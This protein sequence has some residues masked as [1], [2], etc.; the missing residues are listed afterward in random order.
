MVVHLKLDIRDILV[1]ISVNVYSAIKSIVAQKC[2][3]SPTYFF[4]ESDINARG[5][6]FLQQEKLE[7]A[8]VMFKCNVDMFP[9]SWNVYD[10]YGEALFRLGDFAA[11]I[12]NY[13]KSLE[14]N[15]ES[16]SGKEMLEQART[17]AAGS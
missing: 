9:E 15:P 4:L 7:Q 14:L 13:E 6:R 5:Y 8:A 1:I 2:V 17:A 12:V 10:S 3:K 11:S 16:P